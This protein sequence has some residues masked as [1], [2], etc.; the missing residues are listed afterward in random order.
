MY[1]TEQ[2]PPVE[3]IGTKR[4]W[5]GKPNARGQA[6]PVSSSQNQDIRASQSGENSDVLSKIRGL[7]NVLENN[8]R[9]VDFH[10]NGQVAKDDFVNIVFDSTKEYLQPA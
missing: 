10:Q 2:D 5:F 1:Y 3:I 4:H 9:N 8:L 7:K 6:H